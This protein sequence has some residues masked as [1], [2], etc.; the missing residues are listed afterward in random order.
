MREKRDSDIICEVNKNI[1]A[2]QINNVKISLRRDTLENWTA[3][4]TKVLF[5]GEVAIVADGV[6]QNIKIGDGSTQFK[7]LPYLFQK[8]LSAEA[9][10]QGVKCDA[11]P[12]GLAGGI[13]AK[14]AGAAS[15]ALGFAARSLSSYSFTWNG[16][17]A[18]APEHLNGTPYTDHGE[19]TFNVNPKDGIN[20]FYI[21]DQ[22][23]SSLLSANGSEDLS[24]VSAVIQAE[25]AAEA[26]SRIQGDDILSGAIGPVNQLLDQLNGEVV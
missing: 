20:G 17:L 6:D 12:T 8:G 18:K 16:D 3:N 7:D 15:Q 14:A 4:Q 10:A 23:L 22:T 1:M 5:P 2:K 24:A 9:I 11:N 26:A 25:I 21:G 13:Y 19:G